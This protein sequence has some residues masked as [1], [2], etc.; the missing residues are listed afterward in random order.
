MDA[1]E[2]VVIWHDAENTLIATETDGYKLRRNVLHAVRNCLPGGMEEDGLLMV[3]WQLVLP[4]AAITHDLRTG[5]LRMLNQLGVNHI[6]PGDKHG[7]CDVKIKSLIDNWITDHGRFMNSDNRHV[8]SRTAAV[9]LSGDSDFASEILRLRRFGVHVIVVHNAQNGSRALSACATAV[10]PKWEDILRDSRGGERA[11]SV[12]PAQPLDQLLALIKEAGNGGIVGSAIP[13]Q[14]QK[15]TSVVFPLKVSKAIAE[16]RSRGINIRE[17]PRGKDKCYWLDSSARLSTGS[18]KSHVP[19]APKPKSAPP[20]LFIGLPQHQTAAPL[21]SPTTIVQQ[22]LIF[23]DPRPS[24]PP[25]RKRGQGDQE[26]HKS[27]RLSSTA[28]AW[29]APPPKCTHPR[30]QVEQIFNKMQNV[31]RMVCDIPSS[32][33]ETQLALLFYQRTKQRLASYLGG[34][35]VH[36]VGCLFG[37]KSGVFE[38]VGLCYYADLR[39]KCLSQDTKDAICRAISR[40][41]AS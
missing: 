36:Q 21:T 3:Q 33:S 34:W 20:S 26:E 7:A 29:T 11:P 28:A 16:L 23:T 17:R 31:H 35:H 22:Q 13:A 41:P 38:G 2:H 10:I 14:F 8:L 6:D 1:V 4:H 12:P 30:P 39:G 24:T 15:K 9:L 25:A 5:P 18:P 27:S 40:N 19:P 32:I 37:W